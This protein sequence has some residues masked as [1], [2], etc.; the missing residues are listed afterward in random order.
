MPGTQARARTRAGHGCPVLGQNG[1]RLDGYRERESEGEGGARADVRLD[2][3][4]GCAVW[5]R[6]RTWTCVSRVQRACVRR[7]PEQPIGQPNA[8]SFPCI[9]TTILLL[10]IIIVTTNNKYYYFEQ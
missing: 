6:T 3:P 10:I 5:S 4:D 8:L 9:I 1:W 2:L 7:C